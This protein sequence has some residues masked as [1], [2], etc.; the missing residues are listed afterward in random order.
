MLLALYCLPQDYVEIFMSLTAT[1]HDC[2]SLQEYLSP[3]RK[4][5]D[6]QFDTDIRNQ[7]R[8]LADVSE[9]KQH[10]SIVCLQWKTS[11]RVRIGMVT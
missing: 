6:R 4:S 10:I 7:V 8:A 2:F 5:S 11:S 3:C 9:C 1:L